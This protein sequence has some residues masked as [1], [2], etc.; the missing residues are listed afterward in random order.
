ML[1]KILIT[2]AIAM[3]TASFCLAQPTAPAPPADP[4]KTY[5]NKVQACKKQATDKRLLGE[6]RRAFIAECV[7]A[8]PTI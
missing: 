7:K 2:T 1:K 4:H 6:E 8:V 5:H 3:Q